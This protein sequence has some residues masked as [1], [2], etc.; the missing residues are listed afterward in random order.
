VLTF[1]PSSPI[2]QLLLLGAHADDIEIG[3]GGTVLRL[4]AENPEMIVRY[5]V[6]SGSANRQA[7]ARAAASQL[8]YSASKNDVTFYTFKDGYL[9]FDPS[10][11]DAFEEIKQT[12]QPDLI[13]TH[14]R[15]DAHQDHR[16]INALTWNTWRDHS[17][18]E[19]EIPKWDG[20]IGQPNVFVPLTDLIV[21]K[22]ISILLSSFASQASK[23]WFDE[24]TFKGLMR[25][26]GIESNVRYA[27]AFTARKI[28][29]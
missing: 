17:I 27:E 8:L 10:I 16:T 6:F 13:L 2:R 21:D 28:V 1:R 29:L 19:Y 24:E 5:V 3:C 4:I 11:K 18:L 25:L 7:E 15:D 22:K 9:P 26:R 14:R 20:D 23:H 12:F